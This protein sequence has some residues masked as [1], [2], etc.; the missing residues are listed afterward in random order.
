MLDIF[1]TN[2]YIKS[3]SFLRNAFFASSLYFPH[4]KM[5]AHFNSTSMTHNSWSRPYQT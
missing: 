4:H 3:F 1:T 5:G 2:P